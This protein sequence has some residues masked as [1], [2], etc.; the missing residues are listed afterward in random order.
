MNSPDF[1]RNTFDPAG[2]IFGL[3]TSDATREEILALDPEIPLV[4]P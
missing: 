4:T 3:V 2:M 1:E